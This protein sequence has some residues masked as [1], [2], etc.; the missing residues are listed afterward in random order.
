[1]NENLR[2]FLHEFVVVYFDDIVIFSETL[3]DHVRR[4][5][6]RLRERKNQFETKKCEFA[7]KSIWDAWSTEN[8][9]GCRTKS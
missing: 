4:V 6:Q 5:L 1:M 3:E 2:E 9:L 8:L 7:V